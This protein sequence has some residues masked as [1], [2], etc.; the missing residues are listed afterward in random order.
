VGGFGIDIRRV[1]LGTGWQVE[2]MDV[3]GLALA[4]VLI[5]RGLRPRDP[6]RLALALVLLHTTY[7]ATRDALYFGDF[8]HAPPY[9][10]MAFAWVAGG[11]AGDDAFASWRG[12][13]PLGCMAVLLGHR[14]MSGGITPLPGMLLAAAG[15]LAAGCLAAP[16]IRE[17]LAA[18]FVGVALFSLRP[19]P[20]AYP[21]LGY[22][23]AVRWAHELL[24]V[25]P[26]VV[27]SAGLISRMP[28]GTPFP[29]QDPV[30][31]IVWPRHRPAPLAA[32]LTRPPDYRW[33]SNEPV[34]AVVETEPHGWG[35]PYFAG[36]ERT[37]L[38]ERVVRWLAERTR[39]GAPVRT[40][41]STG[42]MLLLALH[43]AEE[44]C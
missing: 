24:S 39:S 44:G 22:P 5:W 15:M 18:L 31:A 28:D 40:V 41:E 23:E 42:R 29:T 10:A 7:A 38:M 9:Y 16:R 43:D 30:Q 4:G 34:Y 26:G 1:V 32:L 6:L 33:P 20:V 19:Q 21:H 11:L 14:I 12:I 27:F 37:A 25:P 3:L 13:A 17:S 35:F 2:A 8:G 36:E